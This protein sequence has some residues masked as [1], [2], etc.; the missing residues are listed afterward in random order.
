MSRMKKEMIR[1]AKLPPIR[2]R[3]LIS[4]LHRIL[5]SIQLADLPSRVREM[6]DERTVRF[7]TTVGLLA[8]PLKFDGRRA[9]Y[10]RIHLLQLL[11]IKRLQSQGHSIR[12]IHLM[13]RVASAAKLAAVA[14]VDTAAAHKAILEAA[15]DPSLDMWPRQ[16]GPVASSDVVASESSPQVKSYDPSPYGLPPVR[17]YRLAEGVYL[18]IDKHVFTPSDDIRQ[19]IF[20]IFEQISGA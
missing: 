15:H 16:G 11:A 14:G 17:T 13:L 10:G 3:T 1:S 4:A 9:L 18:T 5:S 8:P 20:K 6:P 12:A 19:G 7:Y 2:L